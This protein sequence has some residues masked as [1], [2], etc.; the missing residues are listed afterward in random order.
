M[1]HNKKRILIA[2]TML[3]AGSF[4]LLRSRRG[5]GIDATSVAPSDLQEIESPTRD[6][7]MSDVLELAQAA[8]EHIA[9]NLNDYTATFIKQEADERG[10]LGEETVIQLKVQTRLRNDTDDAP[11]RVYL[12]FT[13]PESYKGRE[14]LWGEDIYDG[15]MAVHETG[16]LLGFKTIWL[17]PNGMIAMQGQR[18]PISEIGL[19]RLVEKLIERGEK[20]RHNPNVVV[21]ITHD[22]KIGD[23]P[24]QLIQVRRTQPSGDDK[25][26]FALAEIAIDP[27][28]QLILQYRSFGWPSPDNPSGSTDLPLQESYT[29]QNIQ[30]NV[31]LTDSDFDVKNPLYNFP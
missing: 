8:R 12:R 24:A 6:A 7:T 27:E 3:V 2:V 29:Y 21:T 23:V 28:R 22:H 11:M 25:E 4:L 15:Q 19:T 31:G 5:S 9:T 10:T 13:A 18:Y 1:T 16:L 17:D 30:T 14:V 26:D 20:D